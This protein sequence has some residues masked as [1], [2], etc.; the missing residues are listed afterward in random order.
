MERGQRSGLRRA[1][2]GLGSLSRSAAKSA[3]GLMSRTLPLPHAVRAS[4]WR[5]WTDFGPIEDRNSTL[6]P[7]TIRRCYEYA[8]DHFGNGERYARELA[9]CASIHGSWRDGWIPQSYFLDEIVKKSSG[10][11]ELSRE[12][13]LSNFILRTDAL[14]DIGYVCRGSFFDR[15]W[16][17]LAAADAV[18]VLFAG[19]DRIVFKTNRSNRGNGVT[20]M[21]RGDFDPEKIRLLGDG[22]VQSYIRPHPAVPFAAM[23]AVPTLR[24]VTTI[25]RSGRVTPRFA[26]LRLGRGAHTHVRT[27]DNVKMMVSLETGALAATG[28]LSDWTRIT[29]HPDMREVFAGMTYPDM[30]AGIALCLDLHARVPCFPSIGWDICLSDEGRF[31]IMEWNQFHGILFAEAVNG[32]NFVDLGWER[33]TASAGRDAA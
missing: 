22:C 9:I 28:Y 3:F 25:A 13:T 4:V 20:V 10:V 32:P 23:G 12:K 1:A 17:R 27:E 5:R 2:A 11:P 6:D 31:C 15:D 16:K 18:E 8:A 14:P 21:T 30:Q 19:R 33:R 24:V 7:A 26:H 29:A